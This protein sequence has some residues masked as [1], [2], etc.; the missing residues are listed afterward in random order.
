MRAPFIDDDRGDFVFTKGP[1][2]QITHP[3]IELDWIPRFEEGH[4]A[5]A[6]GGYN[7]Y[8]VDY[9]LEDRTGLDLLREAARYQLEAPV[10]H[11]GQP[12][13]S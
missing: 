9:F 4:N 6:Q 8:L 13:Q 1:L 5:L 3:K 11:A 2:S 12:R 10:D 7:I